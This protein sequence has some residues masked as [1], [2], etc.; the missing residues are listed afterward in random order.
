M[1]VEQCFSRA[2]LVNCCIYVL[3]SSALRRVKTADVLR[4][5]T[6]DNS[7]SEDTRQAKVKRNGVNF[8]FKETYKCFFFQSFLHFC[9]TFLRIVVEF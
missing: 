6:A 4:V 9:F 1:V 8:T 3:P 2:R 7:Q 5:P